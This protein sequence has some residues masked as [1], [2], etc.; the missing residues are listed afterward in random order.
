M[1]NMKKRRWILWLSALGLIAAIS[2]TIFLQIIIHSNVPELAEGS[3]EQ[4]YAQQGSYHV[5]VK[6]VKSTS[7]EALY[8]IYYPAFQADESYPII[9]WGNGTGATPDRYDGLLTHLAS[10]GFIVIDSYSQTTGTGR[11]IVEAIDYL[12]KENGLTNSLFY[13]KIQMEQIGVA[14][15]SQGSTG[16]INAHTNYKSGSLIKTVVSIALPDLKHCDPEDVYDTS[17]IT[18]PF[19]VM[20]GTRDF[21]ISPLS[22]NQ[23]ALHTANASTPVMMGM[24][25]GAAH[26]AIEGEGGNHRGYLTAW[27]RFRLYDDQEA[28]KA[29][30]GASS[31][32]M[33]NTNWVDVMQANM[34]DQ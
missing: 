33:H 7:G 11:E 19:L 5:K 29:F 20:G 32:M 30:Y 4:R 14:G 17:R 31:E 10:W 12:R 9:S 13:Q 28:R 21:I 18:V 15:H 24:A 3:I 27:M 8:R 26:T 2:M 16:V 25:K 22:T 34:D 6:E 23:S 1:P